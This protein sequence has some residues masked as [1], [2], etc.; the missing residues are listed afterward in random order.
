MG[1]AHPTAT[2]PLSPPPRAL[3]RTGYIVWRGNLDKNGVIEIDGNASVPGS[4]DS[5]LPGVPV[6]VDLD[7][8]NFAMVEYPSSSN[9]YRRM[10]I[11]SRNKVQS[12]ILK[13]Q[14][15]D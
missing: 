3:P 11:R 4:I 7:T 2:P 5:G 14:L 1:D 8:K 12:I 10:R 13:W 6:T 9:G 15:A